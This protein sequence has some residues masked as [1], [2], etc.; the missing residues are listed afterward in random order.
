MKKEYKYI[1]FVEIGKNLKTFIWDCR[2]KRSGYSLGV[3]KWYGPWRQ[4][5]F[6]PNGFSIFN[7]GCLSDVMDFVNHVMSMRKNGDVSSAVE[8]SPY[9]AEDTGSNPVVTTDGELE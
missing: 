2:N 7:N 1:E 8:R 3:V 5:C 9:K 4:Y 6:W